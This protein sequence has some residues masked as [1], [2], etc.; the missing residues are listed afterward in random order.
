MQK[1]TA[2]NGA[3]SFKNQIKENEKKLFLHNFPGRYNFTI[4]F[5]IH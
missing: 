5:Y 4:A 3:A 2:P 1:K